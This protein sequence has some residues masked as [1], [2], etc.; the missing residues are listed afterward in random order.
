MS[1]SACPQLTVPRIRP[2]MAFCSPSR[3]VRSRSEIWRLVLPTA[4]AASCSN[5]TQV[6]SVSG[7]NPSR[8]WVTKLPSTLPPKRSPMSWTMGLA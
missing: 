6:L 3:M 4:L 1:A 7:V 5:V 8:S 2:E